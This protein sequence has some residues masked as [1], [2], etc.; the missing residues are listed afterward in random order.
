MNLTITKE[1]ISHGLQSVQ[2]VVSTRTELHALCQEAGLEVVEET[3]FSRFSI[4]VA[5]KA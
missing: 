5:D 2:N 3:S 4:L 1:Q